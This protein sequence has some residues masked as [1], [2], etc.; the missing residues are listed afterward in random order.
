MTPSL[1]KEL[2]EVK[3]AIKNEVREAV[4]E[5]RTP[6]DTTAKLAKTVDIDKVKWVLAETVKANDWDGRYSSR[7]KDWAKQLYIPVLHGEDG[8]QYGAF[9]G[10]HPA[11]I[12]QL[13]EAIITAA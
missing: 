3:E 4:A 7:V 12:N 9:D 6:A 5:K 10:P 8:R 13:I 1:Y 11:H 2:R